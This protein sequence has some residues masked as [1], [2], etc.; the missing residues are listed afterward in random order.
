MQC[1][2]KR[3]QMWDGKERGS[4]FR[5]DMTWDPGS[6]H[7]LGGRWDDWCTLVTSTQEA[8]RFQVLGQPGLQIF[9]GD[10]DLRFMLVRC[11]MS[12][13]TQEAVAE[14]SVDPRN[15]KPAWTTKGDPIKRAEGPRK[16]G[17]RRNSLFHKLVSIPRVALIQMNP[18][19]SI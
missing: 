7:W 14:R 5:S 2:Q 10:L 4:W 11:Q 12:G 13:V 1:G 8:E 9:Y 16:R 3:S 19:N 18:G 6:E 15:S 17:N